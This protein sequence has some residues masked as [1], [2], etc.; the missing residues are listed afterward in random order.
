M[1]KIKYLVKGYTPEIIM[2]DRRLPNVTRDIV[3]KITDG[4]PLMQESI[5]TKEE[6]ERL[7]KMQAVARSNT[8][9]LFN[10]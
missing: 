1:S 3:K 8:R 6:Q 4:R 10:W 9:S 2:Q 7:E 5:K